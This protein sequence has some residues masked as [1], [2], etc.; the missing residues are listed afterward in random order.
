MSTKGLSKEEIEDLKEVV[1]S[2]ENNKE[3]V[4]W[5]SANLFKL[6]EPNFRL[7]E[8]KFLC[9]QVPIEKSFKKL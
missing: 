9:Y 4:P 7:A 3:L 1:S 5:K 8:E 6:V 2:N